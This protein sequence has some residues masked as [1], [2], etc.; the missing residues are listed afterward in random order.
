MCRLI[1]YI[2]RWPVILIFGSGEHLQQPVYVGDVALA[3]MHALES[4]KTIGKRYNVSGFAPLTFN[5]VL[6]TISGL[7]G[8]KVRKLHLPASPVVGALSI[9]ERL[10]F[11]LPI[12]AEQVL[13][14]NENKAFDYFEAAEDFGYRPRSLAEGITLELQEMKLI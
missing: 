3:V 6:D 5:Q 8:R 9:L 10:P 11:R 12:K 13:R 1:G 7:I 2:R 14:L 4:P